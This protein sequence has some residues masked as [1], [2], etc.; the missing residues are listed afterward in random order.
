MAEKSET[1]TLKVLITKRGS[2][3]GQ[4]TMFKK[5]LDSIQV[6]DSDELTPLDIA[7][8]TL[9]LSKFEILSA[10]FEEVQSEIEVLNCHALEVEIDE[11]DSQH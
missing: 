3:K 2:I 9:K 11:R 4:I 6:K 8:L 1:S 5:Y 10:K 7:E